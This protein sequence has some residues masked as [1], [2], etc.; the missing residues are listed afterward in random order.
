LKGSVTSYIFGGFTSIKWNREEGYISDPN[1]FL[2]SLTNKDNQ[3]F[4]MRQ[5]ET[6]YFYS[7]YCDPA[8]G[9]TFGGTDLHICDSANTTAGCYSKSG[10]SYK[11]PQPDQ[12]DSYLAGS[13]E[14]QLSEI[15]VFK[16]E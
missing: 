3:S 13:D 8:N 10:F 11:H 7:I 5:I 16:K 12:C 6:D 4:K 2:F 1:A 15:E 14:F 9:P